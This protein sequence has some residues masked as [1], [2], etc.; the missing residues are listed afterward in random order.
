[1]HFCVNFMPEFTY[2]KS[3]HMST[4]SEE[5]QARSGFGDVQ[6]CVCV[7]VCARA[8]RGEGTNSS[9]TKKFSHW[10]KTEFGGDI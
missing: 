10:E 1:M 6:Q 7:C 5:L 4:S 2:I 9:K 8:H 3:K